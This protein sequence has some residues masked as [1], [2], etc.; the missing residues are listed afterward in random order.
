[1]ETKCSGWKQNVQENV[2][3]ER[4]WMEKEIEEITHIRTS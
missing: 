4:D 1:V 3:S 2:H